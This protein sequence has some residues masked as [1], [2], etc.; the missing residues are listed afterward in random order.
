M[1]AEYSINWA[2]KA[3]MAIAVLLLAAA[4]LFA[5]VNQADAD[6]PA[7]QPDLQAPAPPTAESPPAPPTAENLPAPEPP[8][9][10]DGSA[11]EP[12]GTGNG[13]SDDTT[14]PPTA[15]S[16][17]PPT[18]DDGSDPDHQ[19][20]PADQTTLT[21]DKVF[22]PDPSAPSRIDLLLTLS[23]G[24]HPPAANEVLATITLNNMP[25]REL[26][27]A[28]FE[29]PSSGSYLP[30]TVVLSDPGAYDFVCAAGIRAVGS[31]ATGVIPVL[32]PENPAP[33]AMDYSEAR[34]VGGLVG[35]GH[36]IDT[37][38]PAEVIGM[39]DPSQAP[40]QSSYFSA[41][42]GGQIA[43]GGGVF[44]SGEFL[45]L[46]RQP[47]FVSAV[48]ASE[49]VLGGDPAEVVLRVYVKRERTEGSFVDLRVSV[50][51]IDVKF[52]ADAAP[53]LEYGSNADGFG[54]KQQVLSPSFLNGLFTVS[55]G[56]ADVGQLFETPLQDLVSIDAGTQGQP[57]L[58]SDSVTITP[59]SGVVLADTANYSLDLSGSVDAK[60]AA[61]SPVLDAP[62]LAQL[63]K[64]A[65]GSPARAADGSVWLHS[66]QVVLD[67]RGTG[68]Q[69]GKLLGS[70][71]GA[72]SLSE[73]IE[74]INYGQIGEYYLKETAVPSPRPAYRMPSVRLDISVPV[75]ASAA[76][77]EP[78]V[79]YRET[80]D[81]AG[82]WA[83]GTDA[84]VAI[85]LQDTQ[86]PQP[87]AG[88]LSSLLPPSASPPAPAAVS[89]DSGIDPAS[90][91]VAYDGQTQPRYEYDAGASILYIT[92][93]DS[94]HAWELAS[95][96]IAFSDKAGNALSL[97]ETDV[98][99][100][101]QDPQAMRGIGRIIS[102]TN[103]A[104]LSVAF[105]SPGGSAYYSEARTATFTLSDPYL[106]DA[107]A[108][109]PQRA[110]AQAGPA[111]SA[112]SIP[113]SA[114]TAPVDG[115]PPNTP[116]AY[117]HSFDGDG[118]YQASAAYTNISG[119]VS[120]LPQERFTIDTMEPMV[121][122]E[123]DNNDARSQGFFAAPRTATIRVMEK[124]FSPAAVSVAMTAEGF[125]GQPIAAPALS[126][127]S[128]NG[129]EHTATAYFGQEGSFSLA[130]SATD[131]AGNA[132]EAFEEPRFSIDMTYPVITVRGVADRTAYTGIIAPAA[133]MQD[134]NI[135][136]Y[137]TSVTITKAT[138]SRVSWESSRATP[139]ASTVKVAF[140][141]MSYDTQNDDVYTMVT[142]ATDKA[143]NTTTDLRTFSINR[144]GSTYLV[145]APTARVI[146]THMSR[147]QDIVVTEI[148]P[149]GLQEP[150]IQVRL[151]HDGSSK[152]LTRGQ[153]F[154]IARANVLTPWQDYS[155]TV[156][157]SCFASDGYYEL[158][159]R[160]IDNA[161]LVSESSMDSKRITPR[162]S[163]DRPH[164]GTVYD[165][166]ERT[167]TAIVSFV[168]DT[169][170]PIASLGT[171]HDYEAFLGDGALIDLAFEDNV[172][173][174]RAVLTVDGV[175]VA[176][177]SSS[178]TQAASFGTAT[179][180][181]KPSD[182][183]QTVSLTVWDKAGNHS[184]E[185]RQSITVTSDPVAAWAASRWIPNI[186]IAA[187]IAAVALLVLIAWLL[188]ARRRRREEMKDRLVF[189]R[190]ANRR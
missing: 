21:V 145:S 62:A 161:G 95:L 63:I 39:I 11:T 43:I 179:Y 58:P 28:D 168:V 185:T 76:F 118:D 103:P 154:D 113:I 147:S 47:G 61:P 9:A 41:V 165:T 117:T 176:K 129:D 114:L 164:Q 34:P 160:S 143:G 116:Y 184:T 177:Y 135:E 84:V 108:Y 146:G 130:V 52:N 65:D 5:L 10:S 14:E 98:V 151:G 51:K 83:Y 155:Y 112:A 172:A 170:A 81:I 104:G 89:E 119:L 45:D 139:D 93:F 18:V 77:P 167:G 156:Y 48:R 71:D 72:E 35:L 159:F 49:A 53:V 97:S 31:L 189:A 36:T 6:E 150:E 122:I 70:I 120:E 115:A 54:I 50:N 137:G 123:F 181:L 110:F 78:A 20:P 38:R 15:D 125:D 44:G 24:S 190:P 3:A 17:A 88:P 22:F 59:G 163:D 138:G 4:S 27:L 37:S 91:R 174:D 152:L 1:R 2:S 105:S 131:A 33:R 40:S 149:S 80:Q 60:F 100:L 57:L 141:D 187:A 67:G 121:I 92:L 107:L 173:I 106:R 109:D 23:V 69:F 13:Q 85:V 74:G 66:E 12:P 26:R 99:A 136:S 180:T 96:H 140:G 183:P 79:R 188:L 126:G 127:W 144:F 124:N 64:N 182:K 171:L 186:T 32:A 90:V 16:G 157:A 134:T 73:Y 42:S 178:D 101:S 133:T 56:T 169:T 132:S 25:Y 8:P 75:A 87:S 102:C 30:L 94:G 46:S 19:V 148:N 29:N 68:Y 86:P 162:A 128:S 55:F 142:T 82:A 158:Y 153:D 111:A 175:M 166:H 7:S